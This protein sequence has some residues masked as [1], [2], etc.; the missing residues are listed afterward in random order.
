M[1]FDCLK[2]LLPR[3]V[4]D[5]I[6]DN[7][8]VDKI[9]EIRLRSPFPV[10]LQYADKRLF[11][12]ADGGGR[13]YENAI[14]VT[15]EEINGIIINASQRS[16]Y[17]Y[18]DDIIKGFLSPGSGIRIGVCGE[19]VTSKNNVV[20]L[21]NYSSINIRIPHEISGCSR[22]IIPDIVSSSCKCMIISPPGCG[23]TTILRDIAK[24]LSALQY[25]VL[26]VDERNE[27]ACVRNGVPEM[28]VGKTTDVIS[29]ATKAHAFESAIRSMRP[30]VI[31]TDEI[32]GKEDVDVITEAIGCGIGV[33]ASAHSDGKDV[34]EKRSFTERLIKNKIFNRYYFL[35]F[36]FPSG[37]KIAS[38][39]RNL[40]KIYV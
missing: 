30:D 12:R 26:I 7:F 31:I 25:N 4:Y 19:V 5:A 9:R 16:V 17:A 20:T 29:C 33:I 11:L 23:K 36:D 21:K 10:T 15:Q 37:G 24:Q 22:S 28:D 3:K 13:E 39:D 32:F 27:I 2:T 6:F 38:Y 40:E 18:N 14:T 1:N 34:F 8:N 35:P